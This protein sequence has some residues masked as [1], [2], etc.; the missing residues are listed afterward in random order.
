M[1]MKKYGKTVLIAGI[2][3]LVISGIIPTVNADGWHPSEEYLHLYEPVQKAVIYWDGYSETLI[4]SSAVRSETLT[5]IAWVVPIIS[6]TK[7]EVSSGNM[8]LFEELVGFF[9]PSYYWYS[10]FH[11]A[12]RDTLYNGNI[13]IIEVKEIDIYDII[14]IKAQNTSDLIDWLKD[15]N[16]QVPEEAYDVIDKYVKTENCYFVINKIDLKNRFKDI[17]E[18]LENGT[19]PE[20]MTEYNQ[21]LDDLKNGLATPLKFEFTPLSP[22]Y[23]L[24]ISTLNK[25][26]GKIEVYVIAEKPVADKNNVMQVDIC[27]KITDELKEKLE[28]YFSV[29]KAQYVTRLFYYGL[30]KDLSD[31]AVFEFFILSN[32][33]RPVYY[34]IPMSLKNLSGKIELDI[35]TWASE[36]KIFELQYRIDQKGPWMV[37]TNNDIQF[38]FQFW[39]NIYDYD[40]HIHE[41]NGGIWTIEINTTHLSDGKH[42][43]EFHVLRK[44]GDFIYYTPVVVQNFSVN[45]SIKKSDIDENSVNLNPAIILSSLII[46]SMF[47]VAVISRKTTLN[48]H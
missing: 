46:L 8:S 44:Y 12:E 16:L 19:T 28:Q 25:G 41:N 30:L 7:P 3:M 15:N 17:L 32:P 5:N 11:K 23:P 6:T 13:T 27:K 22:Y 18:Q 20:N 9:E 35:I 43:L 10:Y 24:V 45:N 34:H 2:L 38:Y 33:N 47:T 36:G 40:Y 48:K 37:A 21:V 42:T 4:L 14:I 26:D 31:D 39:M 29:E 1:M